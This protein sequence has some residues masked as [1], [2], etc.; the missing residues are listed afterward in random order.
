MRGEGGREGGEGAR[1][2]LVV[3]LYPPRIFIRTFPLTLPPPFF[4]FLSTPPLPRTTVTSPTRSTSPSPPQGGAPSPLLAARG[5]QAGREG[6]R[7][8][9]DDF[10]CIAKMVAAAAVAGACRVR[11]GRKE[12]GRMSFGVLYDVRRKGRKERREGRGEER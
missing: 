11:V 6:G 5:R 10:G 1:N 2:K 9:K 3:T 8:G 4:P 7:E 12:G